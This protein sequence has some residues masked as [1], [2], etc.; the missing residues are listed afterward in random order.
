MNFN[1]HYNTKLTD[2][3]FKDIPLQKQ[4]KSIDLP[5]INNN[6]ILDKSIEHSY[7]DKSV[8]YKVNPVKKHIINDLSS[9]YDKYEDITR[10]TSLKHDS[11]KL[12]RRNLQSEILDYNQ[13]FFNNFKV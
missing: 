5:K 11:K 8:N 10:P 3:G 9:I 1:N 12:N 7:I 2:Y 4:Y 13:R 6:K